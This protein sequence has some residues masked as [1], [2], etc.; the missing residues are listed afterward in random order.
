MVDGALSRQP[1]FWVF[2][3]T[4][5]HHPS[6]LVQRFNL[7]P[8]PMLPNSVTVA[9]SGVHQAFQLALAAQEAGLLEAFLCSMQARPGKLG[10][11]LAAVMGSAAA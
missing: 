8:S 7:K 5:I 3:S 1:V 6:S 9:Y 4:I 11:R 2:L 10:G